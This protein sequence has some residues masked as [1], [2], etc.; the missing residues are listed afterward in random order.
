MPDDASGAATPR[1]FVSYSLDD[2]SAAALIKRSLERY[3]PPGSVES[4]SH[5]GTPVVAAVQEM[6][7]SADIFIMLLSEA[8]VRNRM[9]ETETAEALA[10]EGRRR[11]IEIIPVLLEPCDI[12]LALRDRGI[13]DLSADGALGVERLLT[14][15][16]RDR[17]VDFSRLSPS[18]FEAMVADLLRTQGF[19]ITA[20]S[21]GPD[22]GYD[23]AVVRNDKRWL[24]EVKHYSHSRISVG[25]VQK[26][27]ARIANE[28]QGT[29]GLLVTN[30]KVTSV[31]Y[32]YLR[33]L[34]SEKDIHIDVLDGD[35]L[36][37]LIR[38]H[39]GLIHRYFGL[40]FAASAE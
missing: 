21:T 26:V 16:Y 30:S 34:A 12:P 28:G 32:D 40:P 31:T 6:V 14:R 20:I 9:V 1:V 4:I 19:D 24:V 36:R 27:A 17:I 10:S 13:V 2:A 25:V 11:A 8:S 23:F 7:R 38:P 5:P 3:L 39:D 33:Y 29:N 18:N 35:D 37:R 15:I 22:M